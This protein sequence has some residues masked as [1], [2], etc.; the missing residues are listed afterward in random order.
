MRGPARPPIVQIVVGIP[1]RDEAATIADAVVSVARAAAHVAVPVHLVVVDDGSEDETATV[2]A[3]ALA[4]ERGALTGEVLVQRCG[5]VGAA[6]ARALDRGLDATGALPAST[7]LATTDAD[8]TVDRR[9][10]AR[11]LRWAERGI[12]AVAGL[13]DV[14]WAPHQD[15]L[16]RR[17]DAAMASHGTG[18]GHPHVHGANLGLRASWWLR[19]GG[20]GDDADGEDHEL[21]RRLREADA[22]VLGVPDVRVRTSARLTGRVPAGFSGLLRT[23]LPAPGSTGPVA[24]PGVRLAVAP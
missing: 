23:L 17:Y 18:V 9:W 14:T 21:W 20:C 1:A 4:E 3:A 2:A 24:A 15:D 5:T 13:V 11:Q 22:V 12:D 7:W 10:L 6:R 8:S 16:A 19:V